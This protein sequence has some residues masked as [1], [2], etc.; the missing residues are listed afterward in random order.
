MIT[1]NERLKG[2]LYVWNEWKNEWMH[3]VMNDNENAT[4][5]ASK[6][7]G[8]RP[9]AQF[10]RLRDEQTNKPTDRQDLL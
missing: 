10:Q 1:M 3:E 6:V 5:K 8:T 9:L 2:M 4:G 7:T